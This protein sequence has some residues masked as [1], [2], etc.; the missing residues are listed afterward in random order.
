VE[1]IDPGGEHM[2]N[3]ELSEEEQQTLITV[4]EESISDLR[5]EIVHTETEENDPGSCPGDGKGP[6]RKLNNTLSCFA[7]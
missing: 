2:I 7:V 5:G 4:L 3:L 1:T 6:G